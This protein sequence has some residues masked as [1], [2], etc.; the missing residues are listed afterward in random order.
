MNYSDMD[1]YLKNCIILPLDLVLVT[2]EVCRLQLP[3][4]LSSVL[5]QH[6][7]VVMDQFEEVWKLLLAV[8]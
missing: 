4:F 3:M 7:L 2:I 6:R 1:F 8:A 5:A